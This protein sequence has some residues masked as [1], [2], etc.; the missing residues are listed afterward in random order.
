M[1]PL[2]IS[3]ATWCVAG[4]S[5]WFWICAGLI[6]MCRPFWFDELI[7]WHVARLP[8]IA[9]IWSA[10]RAGVDQNLLLSHLCVRLSHAVFGYSHLATRLPALAGFWIMLAGIYLFLK[11]RLPTPYALIGMVF[12]MLTYAWAYAFEARSY[13]IMLGGAGIALASW[14]AAAEGRHRLISLIGIAVGLSA[15]LA[16]HYTAVLL[17]VPFTLGEGVR[18]FDRRKLDLSMWIAFAAAA[19]VTL[20]YPGLLAATRDWALGGLQPDATSVSGFY[21]A[22]LRRVSVIFGS[23]TR[24]SSALEPAPRPRP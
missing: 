11:R 8:T 20:I 23:N 21:S 6:A 12:P 18:S 13:G 5:L 17:A 10:L 4:I 19:P 16:S 14:Q 24:S 3:G 1:K 9:A 2:R 15:A 22:A 7:T